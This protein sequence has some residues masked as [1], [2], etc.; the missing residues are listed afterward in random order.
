MPTPNLLSF[1]SPFGSQNRFL[2]FLLMETFVCMPL[3]FTPTTGFGRKR[4][5]Q[6]HVGRDLAADQLVEL[7]LIGG[8][9]HFAVAVVD[10]KL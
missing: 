10:F 9:Y 5:R 4:R 6:S 3:P 8:R 1:S 2:P 7:N